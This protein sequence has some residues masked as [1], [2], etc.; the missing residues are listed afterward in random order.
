MSLVS[1]T[2]S[3]LGDLKTLEQEIIAVLAESGAALSS[4]QIGARIPNPPDGETLSREIY[5]MKKAGKIE[6]DPLAP[7]PA[8][9]RGN[10]G[11]YRLVDNGPPPAPKR[12]GE[13]TFAEALAGLKAAALEVPEAEVEKIARQYS[14]MIDFDLEPAAPTAAEAPSLAAVNVHT[15]RL[16]AVAFP[17]D[18]HDSIDGAITRAVECYDSDTLKAAVVIACTPLGAI[19]VRPVFVPT[20]AA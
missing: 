12:F 1:Q 13:T 2:L 7:P 11:M 15:E 17:S 9:S 10:V 5:Q 3:Q 20:D 6:H 14:E 16:Y 19:D 18:F 4:K 8:G